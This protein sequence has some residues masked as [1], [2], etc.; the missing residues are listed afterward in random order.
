MARRLKDKLQ[1]AVRKLSYK[2]TVDQLKKR[3]IQKVNVVGLDR[4]AALI[5]TAVHRTLRQRMA[6]GFGG[7]GEI[8]R[9]TK[10]EFLKLVRNA[11]SLEKAH[12]EAVQEKARLQEEV[13][14]LRGE[15]ATVQRRIAEARERMEREERVRRA[16]EDAVLVEEIA[17]L[18]DRCAELDAERARVLREDLV[19]LVL[20]RLESERRRAAE[21]RRTQQSEEMEL[22]KR[23]LQ[24][25]TRALEDTERELHQVRRAKAADT[26]IA[27]VY[28][29]V[30]GLDEHDPLYGR[31]H[32]LMVSIFEANRRLLERD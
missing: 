5:E 8:A 21:A 23:R 15:L 3:G 26:G 19:E 22:L 30:Q 14:K 28:R 27:S 31:K 29:E 16:E 6:A 32:E 13:E 2:T 7:A 4:I 24:K 1:E 10:D 25:V 9:G 11:K 17:A 18:I 12:Q 20:G